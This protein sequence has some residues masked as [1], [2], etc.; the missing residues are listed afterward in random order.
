METL[1]FSETDSTAQNSEAAEIFGRDYVEEDYEKKIARLIN[2]ARNQAKI[3]DKREYGLWIEA[4]RTLRRENCYLAVFMEQAAGSV[5]PPGDLLKSAYTC[6]SRLCLAASEFNPSSVSW[7]IGFR[8]SLLG[9]FVLENLINLDPVTA[10]QRIRLIRHPHHRHQLPEHL[11]RH[12]FIPCGSTMRRDA[13]SAL[14]R[15]AHR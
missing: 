15:H 7:C 10:R 1:S 9:L 13:I 11:I 8:T 6:S 4:T 5:R 14:I 2:S 3:E 12:T